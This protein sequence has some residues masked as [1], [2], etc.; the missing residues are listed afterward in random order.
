MN[1]LIVL[2][3]EPGASE[4]VER[5]KSQRLDA[6]SIPLFSIE[7]VEWKAP[8]A[9]CFDA[10]LLTSANGVRIGGEQLKDLRGLPVHAVGRATADAARDAGFDIASSGEAGVERLLGSLEA[11][12]RL[13]HLCGEDRTSVH[14][15]R[16]KISSVPVYKSRAIEP[17]PEIG[18]ID[19]SVVLVHSPRAGKRL[20]GLADDQNLDRS[21]VSLVAI[22]AAAADAAGPGWKIVEVADHPDDDALL[23]LAK[24]LCDNRRE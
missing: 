10:L 23:A 18:D 11:D 17:A 1:V 16:Q 9:G 8:A 2:R 14:K 13:L 7:P 3:P 21:K 22:S 12:L 20:A 6:V 15:T 19:G 5:A 4:T 24:R